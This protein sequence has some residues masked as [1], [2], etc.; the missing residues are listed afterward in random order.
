MLCKVFLSAFFAISSFFLWSPS[1]VLSANVQNLEKIPESIV[2]VSSGY[3]IAVDKKYQKLYVFNKSKVFT[4]V[5]EVN[6]STGKNQG[7]KQ[8]SGDAKTP[9]G[10]FFA[11][12][13]LNNPGPPETYGTLAFPLDYPTITDIK[14][15]KNGTNIWI[16][17]T[18]KPIVPFQSNGCVVLNDKDIHTLAKF[19]YLNK[20]PV[21]IA[22]TIQWIPQNQTLSTRVE[23]EKILA[24]WTKGYIEGNMNVIDNLYLRDHQIKGKKREQLTTRLSNIKNIKQ[25]FILEP[26]DISIL[27]QDNV[28]VI[29][30]DQMTNINKDNSFEG[31]FN[32]LALQ[33]INNKWFIIDDVTTPVVALAQAPARKSDTQPAARSEMDSS[34]KEAVHKL[35]TKWA[36]SWES[37]NMAIFRTCY[38]SNFRAQGMNLNQWVNH[39]AMVRERSKRINVRVDNLIVSGGNNQATATFTQHYSSN[40]LKSKGNKRM[41]LRKIN[42]AWKIYRETMK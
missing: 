33:K 37:G 1:H 26:K 4:K 40:L 19:I 21:I 34:S 39:K 14:S 15:G 42:G 31:S 16:H 5:Y 36:E 17:G 24:A 29:L 23:L 38:A 3:V 8:V 7:S 30:F 20:T 12:R 9:T 28:A 2:T 18:S 13:I 22:E 10:V 32:K 27:Q 11:T 25:H 35:I 6:C 41:E